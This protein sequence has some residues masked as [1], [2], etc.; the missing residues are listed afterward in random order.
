MQDQTQKS[1][2]QGMKTFFIVW[3]MQFLS[4]LGSELSSFALGVWIYMQTHQATPF[5]IT[6][7][8]GTLPR[9]LLAPIAG[10]VADRFSRRWL[11]IFADLGNAL[12]TLAMAIIFWTGHMQV[13]MIYIVSFLASITQAFQEPAYS[14][15]VTMLVPK[16]QFTRAGGLIQ[17]GQSVQSILTPLAA[18]L[19]YGVIGLSGL[20]MINFVTCLPAII[21]LLLVRIPQPRRE[22]LESGKK[23]SLL[24]DAVHGWKYLAARSGLMGLTMYFALVNFLLSFASVLTTPLVLSTTNATGLGIVQTT[25]GVG[26]LLGSLLIS[27]WGGPKKNRMG[28]IIGAIMLIA[29]GFIV[30]GI[31][32]GA[33]FVAAGYFLALFV[34]PFASAI[35]RAITQAKVAPEVQGRVF[36]IRSMIS[37]AL[38]PLA[39]LISGPLADKVFEPL[40]QP[41]GSLADGFVGSLLGTG[42]GRGIGFMFVLAG[43]VLIIVSAIAALNPRLRNLETELPDVIQEPSSGVVAQPAPAE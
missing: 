33:V 41:G 6:V 9:V 38:T 19:L 14:A 12:I 32:P 28:V 40:M 29:V 10:T 22:D 1:C 20:F 7:L 5:A 26:M 25:L 11:M 42:L 23:T 34:L 15:S 21:L 35:S 3:G 4:M 17:L 2:P 31:R 39:F 27:I 13:W 16:E 8:F 37:Q 18:G 36:A 24:Q 43:I 30:I